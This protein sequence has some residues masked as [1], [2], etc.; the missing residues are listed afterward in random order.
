MDQLLENP[1]H[2]RA[3]MQLEAQR[4][5]I[6]AICCRYGV[7][8][9]SLFGSIL[10]PEEFHANSDIDFLVEFL[11]GVTHGIAFIEM[12]LELED[13]LERKTELKTALDLS[14][15]FRDEVVAE[16]EVFYAAS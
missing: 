5:Q 8:R 4:A 13:L 6:E 16:A 12:D 10:R 14:R 15:Y 2:A 9:L 3:V 11:P 1:L 7:A